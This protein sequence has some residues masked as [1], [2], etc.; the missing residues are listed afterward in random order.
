MTHIELD[1]NKLLGVRICAVSDEP[2]RSERATELSK[3]AVPATIG[4]K[5]GPKL[6]S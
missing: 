1:T 6:E 2:N 3:L 5:E 4:L